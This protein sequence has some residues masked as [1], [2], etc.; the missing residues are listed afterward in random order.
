MMLPSWLLIG[1]V[2]CFCTHTYVLFF[3][4]YLSRLP[5]FIGLLVVPRPAG[6]FNVAY[7]VAKPASS[8]YSLLF[9]H[10]YLSNFCS[11]H[12]LVDCLHSLVYSVVP[13]PARSYNVA[14]VIAKPASSWHRT[15]FLQSYIST[16][17][18]L[19]LKLT[20]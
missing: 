13:R 5:N 7:V 10:S 1:T 14:H 3:H 8:V 9:L 6:Y 15:L 4:P 17:F 2:H 20:A 16:V 12:A 19:I 11:P 18:A